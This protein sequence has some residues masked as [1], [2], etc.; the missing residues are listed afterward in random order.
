MYLHLGQDTVIK[1]R[2][3]IGIFDLDKSTISKQTRDFLSRA[4]RNGQIINVTTELPKSFV[5]CSKENGFVVYISQISTT[6]LLKRTYYF[7][8]IANI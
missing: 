5:L 3:I 4:E 7:D 1:L 8:E 6:T 2:D